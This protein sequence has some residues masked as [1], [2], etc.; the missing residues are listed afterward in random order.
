M[1]WRSYPLERERKATNWSI[2][3]GRSR[4]HFGTKRNFIRPKRNIFYIILD[5]IRIFKQIH[6][7]YYPKMQHIL[8]ASCGKMTTFGVVEEVY[9]R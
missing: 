7:V 8:N 6:R 3:Q 2:I 4:A 5:E 1:R 9:L